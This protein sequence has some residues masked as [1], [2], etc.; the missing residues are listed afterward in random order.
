MAQV[1]SCTDTE[2]ELR[3]KILLQFQEMATSEVPAE[4]LPLCS[5]SPWDLYR[6]IL[7][8]LPLL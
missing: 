7:L 1:P 8:T 6:K 2:W 5:D 4:L 3:R